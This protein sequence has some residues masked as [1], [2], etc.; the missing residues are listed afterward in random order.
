MTTGKAA[1]QGVGYGALMGL[2][3]GLLFSLLFTTDDASFWGLL[4]FSIVVG[5]LFGG[6][7]GAISQYWTDGRRDFTSKSDT[8]ADHYEV[9]VDDGYAGEAQRVL[10]TMPAH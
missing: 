4:S 3:W 2:I 8:R 6:L 10:S 7:V 5:I 9:Q 1:L